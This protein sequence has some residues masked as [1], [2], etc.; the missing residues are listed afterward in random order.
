MKFILRHIFFFVLQFVV[1]TAA[2]VGGCVAWTLNER[3]KSYAG[4]QAFH[5]DLILY[6]KSGMAVAVFFCL[7]L[8]CYHLTR[9]ALQATPDPNDD[10][11]RF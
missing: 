7:V 9:K 8:F 2:V 6:V 10:G 3:G 11:W 5:A 1:V 4:T